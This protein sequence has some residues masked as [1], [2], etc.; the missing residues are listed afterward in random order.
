MILAGILLKLG[1]YGIMR[2][3][4]ILESFP[5]YLLVFLVVFSVYGGSLVSLICL[6]QVDIKS[7][8]AYSSVVHIRTCIGGLLIIND[9]GFF[10]AFIIILAHGLSSS[11]LFFLIGLVYERRGR[12]SLFVNKGLINIIPRISLLW[13]GLLATNISAP[14]SINLL[15]EIN[16]IIGLLS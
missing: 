11:G 12:R 9:W 14:P 5:L 13:F 2:F 7:L 15:G 6:T 3:F 1:G 8:V 10:G 16:M 4:Y